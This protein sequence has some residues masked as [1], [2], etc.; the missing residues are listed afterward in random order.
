[1]KLECN[2]FNESNVENID[3]FTTYYQQITDVVTDKLSL[4][5]DYSFSIIFVNDDKIKEINR[6]YR[7]IDRETD[8]ITFASMDNMEPFE[9]LQEEIELGDIFISTD[10]IYRQAES[11][12]HSQTRESSFLFTHGILHLFGY[13]HMNEEDEKKMFELQDEIL[14][15]IIPRNKGE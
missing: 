15:P 5:K 6:D 13:D 14:D 8:V 1:M 4:D 7:N 9:L 3:L 11:Y 2:I 10:A 12:Q